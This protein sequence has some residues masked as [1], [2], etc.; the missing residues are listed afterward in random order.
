MPIALTA[1]KKIL[2]RELELHPTAIIDIINQTL[3]PITQS[4]KVIIYVNKDDLALLEKSKGKIKK[5]LEQVKEFSIQERLD[6]KKG[7]CLI[8]TEAGII[9]AQL[10]SQW[11]ALEAALE[12]FHKK[13][14]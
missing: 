12:K 5:Q 13:Q 4:H 8:E 6:V 3:K 9:N 2:G 11:R 7:G 1:A 10:D 14:V